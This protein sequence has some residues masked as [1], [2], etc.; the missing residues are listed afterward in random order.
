[1]DNEMLYFSTQLR[2]ALAARM[3][4]LK[5]EISSSISLKGLWASGKTAESM[6]V[7]V[8]EQEVAL[9]GRPFFAALETGSSRWSGATGIRCSFVEFKGIIRNWAASKGLHFGQ[10]EETERAVANIAR[11]IMNKGTKQ[12]RSGQRLDVYTSLVEQAYEDCTAICADVLNAQVTNVIEK[13]W[14]TR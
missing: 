6:Y 4:K 3:E 1:M 7:V 14:G 8:S 2:D 11:S 5:D 12:K 13:N 9:Y 10:H